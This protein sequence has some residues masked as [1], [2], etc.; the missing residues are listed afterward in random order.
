MEV[1]FGGKF[2]GSAHNISQYKPQRCPVFL[3]ALAFRHRQKI[4]DA[5]ALC[6]KIKKGVGFV[7]Q[8]IIIYGLDSVLVTDS[9]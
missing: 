5:F 9:R 2:R 8:R 4:C 6:Q 7:N 3:Y 1:T